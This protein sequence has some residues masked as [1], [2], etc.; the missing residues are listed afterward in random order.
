MLRSCVIDFKGNSDDHFPLIEFAYNNNYHSSISMAPFKALYGRRCRSPIERLKMAQSRQK[1]FA[2]VTRR[3]LEF[4]VDDWVY[5]KISP[6]QGVIEFGKKEK[7]SPRYMGLYEILRCVGKFSYELDLPN[8]LVLVHQIFHVSLLNK[9]VGDPTSI[10]SLESF[11]IKESLSYEEVQ[12]KILDWQVKKLRNKEVASM[13]VLW[14]NQIV[15]FSTWEAEAD[16]M[17]HYPHLVSS[18]PMLARSI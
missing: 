6:M 7:F 13:K 12:V 8:D 5:L 10:A 4:D 2:D 3:D 18:D 16:M 15:E 17:S 14:R 11:Y 1:S 9:C